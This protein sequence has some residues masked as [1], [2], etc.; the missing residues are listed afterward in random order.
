MPKTTEI[1]AERAADQAWESL[2]KLC[3]E[4][5]FGKI[6]ELTI[7]DGAPVHAEIV[8]RSIKLS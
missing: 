8:R 2:R 5:K 4:I 3:E 6:E 7:R 1:L